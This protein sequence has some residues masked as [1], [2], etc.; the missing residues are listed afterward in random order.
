MER[1]DYQS[2]ANDILCDTD[3]YDKLG[4]NPVPQVEAKTKQ[5]FNQ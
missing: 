3:K 4:K 5:T 2:K 1:T